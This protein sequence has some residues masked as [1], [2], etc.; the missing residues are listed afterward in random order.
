M[1]QEF[2][3]DPSLKDTLVEGVSTV[4]KDIPSPERYAYVFG[5]NAEEVKCVSSVVYVYF[6]LANGSVD[7]EGN[8]CP[9]G[10]KIAVQITGKCPG[11]PEYDAMVRSIKSTF[12]VDAIASVAKV[13]PSR[14]T[15]LSEDEY[16]RKYGADVL[17]KKLAEAAEVLTDDIYRHC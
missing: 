5:K 1:K 4:L 12:T 14:I 8:K 17:R 13:D 9:C 10:S 15:I 16:Y 11:T 2:K 7:K 3:D 6:E